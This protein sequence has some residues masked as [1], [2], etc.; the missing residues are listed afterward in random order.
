VLPQDYSAAAFAS[1]RSQI[2]AAEPE[3]REQ[4]IAIVRDL[5]PPAIGQT[6]RYQTLQALLNCTRRS[7]LPDPEV[8]AETRQEWERE[9]RELERHG[10]T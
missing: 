4:L 6:R 9:I 1:L 10:I 2:K 8:S 5:I 3:S 7:L